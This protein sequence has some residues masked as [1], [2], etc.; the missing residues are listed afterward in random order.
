MPQAGQDDIC[1]GGTTVEKKKQDSET[2]KTDYW[3]SFQ[4]NAIC[5]LAGPPGIIFDPFFFFF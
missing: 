3:V 2:D 5:G 1:Q 4:Q